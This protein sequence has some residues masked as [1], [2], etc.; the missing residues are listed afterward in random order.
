M[1]VHI[2]RTDVRAAQQFCERYRIFARY[3]RE[4]LVY[5]V[6]SIL[7]GGN[8]PAYFT[9]TSTFMAIKLLYEPL[10]YANVP[11]SLLVF[12]AVDQRSGPRPLPVFT[13]RARTCK[14][15]L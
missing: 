3:K 12:F 2:V 9:T 6:A 7:S 8:L 15:S 5:F 13:L 4:V 14:T 10:V 11:L 1:E